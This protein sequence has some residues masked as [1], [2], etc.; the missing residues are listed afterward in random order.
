MYSACAFVCA[1]FTVVPKQFQLFQPM[2]GRAAHDQKAGVPTGAG[3]NAPANA[4]D[5]PGKASNAVALNAPFRNGRRPIRQFDTS[6]SAWELPKEVLCHAK[7]HQTADL[8]S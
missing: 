6:T 1:S 4:I 2:G 7:H 3:G 8:A 5:L